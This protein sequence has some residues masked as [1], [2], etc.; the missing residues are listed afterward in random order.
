M[1]YPSKPCGR[2]TPLR[3]F[4]GWP[5]AIFYPF[6]HPR[7]Y[8]YAY[9]PSPSKVNS[10]PHPPPNSTFYP[11]L[12]SITFH[13]FTFTLPRKLNCLPLIPLPLPS[14]RPPC[15][16][17]CSFGANVT[18]LIP[19]KKGSVVSVQKDLVHRSDPCNQQLFC[20]ERPTSG[21]KL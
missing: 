6:R 4:Q 13:L 11:P 7:G 2:A 18:L 16:S 8:A 12:T 14:P 3:S 19:I 21:A 10:E 17:L 5:A 20:L 15:Y 1:P 9:S